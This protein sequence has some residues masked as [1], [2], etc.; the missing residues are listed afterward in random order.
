MEAICAD[1]LSRRYQ[2]KKG[3]FAKPKSVEALAG[4]S[5]RVG[6]GTVFGLLGQNGAGKTTTLKILS[7]LLLPS[8]G[9]ATVLGLDVTKDAQQI[10]SKVSI[11]FGGE[12]G[13]YGRLTGAENLAMFYNLHALPAAD[14]VAR[15][16][17]L[18]AEVDLSNTVLDRPVMTYSRGMRQKLHLART[19]LNDPALIFL[20]EPT[21]GLDAEAA[22]RFRV[23]VRDLRDQGRTIVLTS[24]YMRDIEELCDHVV[25]LKDGAAVLDTL[26]PDLYRKKIA[27]RQLIDL[28]LHDR[29]Q[30]ERDGLIRALGK[31]G[32][33]ETSRS[34]NFRIIQARADTGTQSMLTEFEGSIRNYSARNV[35]LEDVYLSYVS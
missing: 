26:Y 25:I 4:L 27:N 35:S 17:Q 23:M 1:K 15:I 20:D 24:H 7:T 9:G 31:L 30:A 34:G 22:E 3:I 21:I 16:A 11:M 6:Q 2:S 28:T 14:R 33:R 12:R 13:L 29:D 10:R 8:G 5:F 19:L 18:A 32:A